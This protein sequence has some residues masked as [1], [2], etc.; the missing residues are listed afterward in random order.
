MLERWVTSLARW[1]ALAGGVMLV[2]LTLISVLSISG[3]AIF[4]MAN[5]ADGEGWRAIAYPIMRAIGSMFDKLGAGPIPGD[6]EMVEAG[7]AFA[8]FAFLPWCQLNRSHASV[9]IFTASFPTSLN[10]FIDLISNGLFFAVALL[11]AWRHWLGTMDKLGYGETSF[12]LQY[13]IWWGYAL[14]M[15]GAIVFV[16]VSAYCFLRSIREWR[17][18]ETPVSGGAVH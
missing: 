1:M 11:L 13:P 18:G 9:E 14:S 4:T 15:I 8:V 2:L 12:I 6:Y 16:I 5:L 3:R 10:R 17:D 7:T